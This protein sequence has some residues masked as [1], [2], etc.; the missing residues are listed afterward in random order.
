MFPHTPIAHEADGPGPGDGRKARRPIWLRKWVVFAF[1]LV[2]VA[3]IAALI[4]LHSFALQQDGLQLRW[5]DNHYLWTYG[6]TA[7][8]AVILSL[9][10]RVDG[11]YRL[12]QPWWCLLAGPAPA[13]ESVLLDYT[14][15]FIGVTLFR[16]LR[17]RHYPV[18]AS[19]SVFVLLKLIILASTAVFF[20]GPSSKSVTVPVEYT[21]R[22]SGSDLWTDF[23]YSTIQQGND[24][25][26]DYQMQAGELKAR[27]IGSDK[28]SWSYLAGLDKVAISTGDAETASKR[29]PV[30]QGYRLSDEGLNLT[31]AHVLVDLFLPNVTCEP[32]T[33]VNDVQN[34]EWE[35]EKH[36]LYR[37]ESD[38]CA[39]NSLVLLGN[40]I[41]DGRP[42]ETATFKTQAEVFSPLNCTKGSTDDTR[43][44]IA[45]AQFT[46][47]QI[48]I[49]DEDPVD[50]LYNSTYKPGA[51]AAAICKIEYGIFSTMAHQHANMDKPKFDTN[52]ASAGAKLLPNLTNYD[53]G[54]IVR[55]DV[56]NASA[57]LFVDT[58]TPESSWD[59][60]ETTFHAL[61]ELMHATAGY[62]NHSLATFPS[63]EFAGYSSSVLT[64]LANEFARTSLLVPQANDISEGTGL[65]SEDRL[66]LAPFALW[67]K[68]SALVLSA[69]VCIGII[70]TLPK[71][72]WQ[73]GNASSIAVHASILSGSLSTKMALQDADRCRGRVLRMGLAGTRFWLDTSGSRPSLQLSENPG[74]TMGTLPPK[75]TTT[76]QRGWVPQTARLPVIISTLAYPVLLIAALEVL[77][78]LSKE[79][80]GLLDIDAS[81]S[82]TSFY[83]IRI[84]CTLAVFLVATMFNNLEFTIGSLI[85]FTRLSHGSAPAQHSIAFSPLS[86]FPWTVF[87]RALRRFHIGV[88]ASYLAAMLGAFLTIAVSGLWIPTQQI[89][90]E[91]PGSALVQTWDVAGLNRTG[92]YSGAMRELNNIRHGGAKAASLIVENVVLPR[93]FPEPRF[94]GTHAEDPLESNYTYRD[95]PALRP[96]LDCVQVPAEDVS[97]TPTDVGYSWVFSVNTTHPSICRGQ[98]EEEDAINLSGTMF[99]HYLSLYTEVLSSTPGRDDAQQCPYSVVVV[100]HAEHGNT[101]PAQNSPYRPDLTALVCVQGIEEVQAEVT[102]QGDPRLDKVSKDFARIFS[103]MDPEQRLR[104]GTSP[105]HFNISA[106]TEAYWT[107]FPHQEKGFG[108]I[109]NFFY[110]LIERPGGTRL[111]DL[112]G[113]GNVQKLTGAVT[114]EY[115]EI[116]SY[117]LDKNL[118]RK[119]A[120]LLDIGPVTISN[121]HSGDKQQQ[122]EGLA[123]TTRSIQGLTKYHVRRLTIHEP[124]KLFLQ[125]LLG[126]MALLGLVAYGS[127]RLRGVLPRAPY[128]MASVMGFLAGSQL[129]DLDVVTL[130]EDLGLMTDRELRAAFDGWLFSLG[131]WARANGGE[132]LGPDGTDNEVYD[133]WKTTASSTVLRDYTTGGFSE[134]TGTFN[135]SGSATTITNVDGAST[136]RED[137][138]R[139]AR[140][141]IDIGTASSLGFSDGA[142]LRF[143]RRRRDSGSFRTGRNGSLEC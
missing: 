18:A 99:D 26:W 140:F 108:N 72:R 2:F 97:I 142:R 66:H 141:G 38:T 71:S 122:Q 115:Q 102:Y 127:V 49:P 103:P 78:K 107:E 106:L 126:C 81:G 13:S 119:T 7:I 116:V 15:P 45:I 63:S 88:A 6:P 51:W 109:D 111:E 139:R 59:R 110:Q 137:S 28:S 91:R 93:V 87:Y 73:L 117:I 134:E 113:R 25:D 54:T 23:A 86:L 12:N 70:L 53:L 90:V 112:V 104:N 67:V 16:A 40:Q 94:P 36:L 79:R 125:A 129:C 46:A 1:L 22:F 14:S 35:K 85:P 55:S 37:I 24:W 10:R 61:F 68:V 30:Y 31:R 65:V 48:T 41:A 69:V 75:M 82:M 39:S 101:G 57:T 4:F 20:V 124:S 56:A 128:T 33:L 21:S 77:F 9:W 80:N 52:L 29:E 62:P 3:C 95:I 11:I 133:N 130:P 44:A 114:R 43:Y 19:V 89:R 123:E 58:T 138:S 27:F 76:R 74:V 47:H 42:E 100:A 64:G 120:S 60:L 118:R 98:P 5:H 136:A 132:K 143:R 84:S 34:S 96:V 17:L 121:E 50:R 131:W 32:A 83:A 135:D 105:L 8:L 92:D